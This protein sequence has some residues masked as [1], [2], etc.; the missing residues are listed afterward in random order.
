[1]DKIEIDDFVDL[2]H[3]MI[4]GY[5]F[6]YVDKFKAGLGLGAVF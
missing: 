3:Q 4:F 1:M 2:S 6:I 5:E